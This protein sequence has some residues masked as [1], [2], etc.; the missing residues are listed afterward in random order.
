MVEE[1]K[2]IDRVLAAVELQPMGICT[3]TVQRP[4][5]A[6]WG[7]PGG[8]GPIAARTSERRASGETAR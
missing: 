1:I 4:R 3:A 6:S 8:G 5:S 7:N 2:N